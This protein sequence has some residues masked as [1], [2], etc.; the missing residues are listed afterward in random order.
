MDG[1]PQRGSDTPLD[2]YCGARLRNRPG[3]HC[4]RLPLRGKTRCRH[5]GGLSP[6]GVAHYNFKTGIHS[7]ALAG[8]PLGELYEQARANPD[9]IQLTEQ[10][11]LLDARND[12]LFGQFGTGESQ[13]AWT[14]VREGLSML[15]E[16]QKSR[17]GAAMV[18]ALTTISA[19][20][21]RGENDAA[22]W[23]ELRTNISLRRKLVDS[24]SRR[25]K[26]ALE[27]LDTTRVMAIMGAVAQAVKDEVP[28]PRQRQAVVNRMRMAIAGAPRP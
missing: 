15:R 16:A 27:M 1:R 2:G 28:D 18:A 17:D 10:I 24:E 4:T 6:S 23:A 19:A 22:I 12:Q 5:H 7:K 11:A 13:E 21:D 14:Q 26:D 8:T 20:V 9:I 25:R 3:R